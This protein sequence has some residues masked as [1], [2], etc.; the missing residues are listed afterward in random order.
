MSTGTKHRGMD[1]AYPDAR[2]APALGPLNVNGAGPSRPYAR[3][4][5]GSRRR[6]HP[7]RS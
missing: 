4:E 5:P 2:E 7:G 1:P 3:A 6:E